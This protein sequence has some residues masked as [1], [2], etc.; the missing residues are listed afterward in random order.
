MGGLAMKMQ[1]IA[2]YMARMGIRR[3][4]GAVF[5]MLAGGLAATFIYTAQAQTPQPTA[6]KAASPQSDDVR[7]TLNTY[8][9]GC[10]S[11]KG[12][13]AG[14]DLESIDA[15][16]P[17]QHA[18]IWEKVIGRLRAGSMPPSGMPRPD[19]KA[20]DAVAASLEGSLDRAWAAN[21][22]PGRIGAVQRL[23]RSEYGNAIRDLFAL[24]MDVK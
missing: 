23:N 17:E 2:S 24:D 6:A 4:M 18:E 21:P 16:H 3:R 11:A 8:C 10:H 14:L 5:V 9:I 13:T 20:Y 22:N 19:A 7:A 12:R 15:A 1:E